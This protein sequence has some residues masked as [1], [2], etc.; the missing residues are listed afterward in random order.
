[1]AALFDYMQDVYRLLGRDEGQE[2]FNPDDIIRWVNL[3]R[4]ETAQQ[5]QCIRRLSPI[6]GSILTLDVTA[7]G[8]GY[9]NPTVTISPPDS[10]TGYLPYPAGAQATGLVQQ[11]GGQISNVSVDFGGSGY[12]A[13]TVTIDDPTGVGAVVVPGITP[14]LATTFN[15]ELFLFSD[16]P[17]QSLPG[18]Q[19][20]LSVRSVA[21][22]WTELQ[23]TCAR[24]S[25]SRYQAI[26]KNWANTYNAPPVICCQFGQGTDGSLK[27]F[28]LA[29]QAYQLQLDMLCLP[30]DL[31][32]DAD[33]EAIPAPWT[34]AV[35]Y[36]AA[37]LGLLSKA[38][39]Q[40]AFLNLALQYYNTKDGG[41]WGMHMK[42][43]RAHSNPGQVG[44]FY[45]RT[46]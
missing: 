4:Q 12:F 26:V 29:D 25:F 17:I 16:V 18:V 9:T 30:M 27:L 31:A 28:P 34:R 39:V 37:H 5:G 36:F 20:I 35:P 46:R 40:P 38:A 43:A 1:M 2:D 10:P 42:R 13:P 7:S 21:V 41:L 45:G 23:W 44:S 6:S 33:F 14:I 24:V 8:H 3:A 32:D 11:I 15:Q 22:L 19:S